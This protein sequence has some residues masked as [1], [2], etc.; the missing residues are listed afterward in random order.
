MTILVVIL[1]MGLG[2]LGILS[3][4]KRSEA[5]KSNYFRKVKGLN[6]FLIW[7]ILSNLLFYIYFLLV[8]LLYNLIIVNSDSSEKID[9]STGGYLTTEDV[10]NEYLS[11]S[12]FLFWLFII[13]N[14]V[15]FFSRFFLK[16]NSNLS[17]RSETNE[18]NYS[19]LLIFLAILACFISLMFLI[20]LLNYSV[21]YGG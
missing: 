19:I 10:A 8:S 6:I 7:L 18:R 2:S 1:S 12:S 17:L 3:L 20:I 15:L 16:P 14:T 21:T 13:V 5:K 4:I 9:G 11:L